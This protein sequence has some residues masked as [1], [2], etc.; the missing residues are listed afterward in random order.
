LLFG[1]A[2]AA[3]QGQQD[4]IASKAIYFPSSHTTMKIILFILLHAWPRC[5]VDAVFLQF[6][7]GSSSYYSF[8]P[9]V[10]ERRS[11]ATPPPQ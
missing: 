1:A 9:F 3:Q 10:A 5:S 6:R 2:G 4:K 7:G 8:D 11:L